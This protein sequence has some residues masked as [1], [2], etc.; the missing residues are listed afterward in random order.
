MSMTKREIDGDEEKGKASA[1][2]KN[3]RDEFST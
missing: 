3:I 1:K 2:Y